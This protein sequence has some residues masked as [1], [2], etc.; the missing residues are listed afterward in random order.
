MLLM[1]PLVHQETLEIKFVQSPTPPNGRFF[2]DS[3]EMYQPRNS[4]HDRAKPAL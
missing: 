1:L 4:S 3:T 2:G